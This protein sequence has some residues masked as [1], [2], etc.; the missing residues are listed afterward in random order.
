M[1]N[2][3]NTVSS[4][5]NENIHSNLYLL[6][7]YV[8]LQIKE[9][10]RV[11]NFSHG[12]NI[13][14]IYTQINSI[15]I[16]NL[17]NKNWIS[18][19]L[20]DNSSNCNTNNDHETENKN[21]SCIKVVD[22]H[23]FFK[24]IRSFIWE[25]KHWK[26]QSNGIVL[27]GCSIIYTKLKYIYVKWSFIRHICF[28]NSLISNHTICA[29][30]PFFYCCALVE[31][32]YLNL[33]NIINTEQ[34][35]SLTF[36]VNDLLLYSIK[37]KSFIRSN[38]SSSLGRNFI[39]YGILKFITVVTTAHHVPFSWVTWIQS[40]PSHPVSMIHCHGQSLLEQRPLWSAVLECTVMRKIVK[41][42][43]HKYSLRYCLCVLRELIIDLSCS[44]WIIAC[45]KC[46]PD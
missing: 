17:V 19:Y 36:Q 34:V 29:K 18:N 15:Q 46:H 38:K 30:M 8:L 40:T 3:V 39:F 6:L 35:R 9:H 28:L 31:L 44:C 24:Y 7:L 41:P 45:N 25:S 37:A 4:A 12:N 20:L 10:T 14:I 26:H 32:I 5:K 33:R 42:L 1:Q 16:V 2:I 43:S 13:P 23:T 27:K 21:N 22:C 11:Y